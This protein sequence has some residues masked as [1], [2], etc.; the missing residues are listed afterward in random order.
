MV[1]GVCKNC[2]GPESWIQIEKRRKEQPEETSDSYEAKRRKEKHLSLL[3]AFIGLFFLIIAIV[4]YINNVSMIYTISYF[5]VALLLLPLFKIKSELRFVGAIVLFALPMFIKPV[6]LDVGN[7]MAKEVVNEQ[8]PKAINTL[9]SKFSYQGEHYG[10]V[11]MMKESMKNPDSYEFV[12][13]EHWTNNNGIFASLKYRGT[14]G[15]SG[16]VTEEVVAT[17]DSS[18]NIVSIS[19]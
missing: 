5:L 4:N 10:L 14:N 12:S 9:D 15:F 18:G 7:S 16:I 13:G 2:I 17:L 6:Y 8:A 1:D 11:K 3:G 19:R